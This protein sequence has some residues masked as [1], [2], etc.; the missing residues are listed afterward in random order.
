MIMPV[1]YVVPDR[2][3]SVGNYYFHKRT[4]IAEN[5]K[6]ETTKQLLDIISL[7]DAAIRIIEQAERL[8]KMKLNI[9]EQ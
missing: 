1:G 9:K 2:F 3:Y 5:K 7:S 4:G 8:E 6:P